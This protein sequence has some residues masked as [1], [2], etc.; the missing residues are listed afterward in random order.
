MTPAERRLAMIRLLAQ[1][2]QRIADAESLA[3]D[4]RLNHEERQSAAAALSFR[5]RA[6][7]R[8]ET[9]LAE[10]GR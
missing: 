10:L 7:E 9:M 6:V 2:D 5:R 1:I 8:I 3:A 4:A